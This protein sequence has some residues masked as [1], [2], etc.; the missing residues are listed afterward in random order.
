MAKFAFPYLIDKAN[1]YKENSIFEFPSS[2]DD[3][4]EF[5]DGS[6]GGSRKKPGD[7]LFTRVLFLVNSHFS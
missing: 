5:L 3:L 6:V 4:R 7:F 2:K 1:Y